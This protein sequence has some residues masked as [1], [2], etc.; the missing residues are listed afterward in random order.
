MLVHELYIQD[1]S[2]DV[3]TYWMMQN[4]ETFW[5]KIFLARLI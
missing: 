4:I 2:L 5:V 3:L 1:R